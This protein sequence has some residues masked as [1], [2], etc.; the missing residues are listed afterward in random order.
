MIIIEKGAK[1]KLPK[2]FHFVNNICAY[3]YDQ[4]AEI[5]SD[6][7]YLD[8]A[9]TTTANSPELNQFLEQDR[10]HPLDA[11]KQLGDNE[12]IELIVTK[13]V[14]MSIISDLVNFIYES[15]VIAQ[16]GK[17][18]V[19]YALLRKPLTDQ[20]LILEQIVADRKDFIDRYFHDGDP[21]K[22]DPS[23]ANLDRKGIVA[24]SIQKLGAMLYSSDLIYELRYDKSSEIGINPFTNHAL[25]IVTNHKHYKTEN[26]GLNFTFPLN[27]E[28]MF[29]YFNHY[30]SAMPVL[31]NYLAAVV[32]H[33]VFE[34]IEDKEGRRVEKMLIRFISYIMLYDDQK[35]SLSKLTYPQLSKLLACECEICKTKNK[36]GKRDFEA[37]FYEHYF[38]C[39]RCFNPLPIAPEA[40][41]NVSKILYRTGES[42]EASDQPNH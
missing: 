24:R 5:L 7:Y 34:L 18:S 23:A 41:E 20:L 16:K 32:D 21:Q 3:L 25:H 14:T 27:D 8:M 9:N 40:L 39:K 22:Y 26:Q 13:H 35:R 10:L 33:I 38:T 30:Y 19:A 1:T 15:I 31:L 2:P 6:T 17:L 37:Y 28:D 4:M 12:A 11:L 42:N 29:E 36:F